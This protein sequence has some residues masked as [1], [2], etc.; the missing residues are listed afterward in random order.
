MKFK[1]FVAGLLNFLWNDVITH[2]PWH[3]FRKFFLR[4][5]N[6]KISATCTVLMHTRILCFWNCVIGERSVI[7][8]YV[9]LDCR[10]S[11][12]VIDEDVDIGPYTRIWT[13]GHNPDSDTHDIYHADVIL[14]HHVW[15]AS[16]VTVL[17]GVTVEEG[18]VL[19]AG[20]LVHKNIPAREVWGG[21]PARFIRKRNNLLQYKLRYKAYFE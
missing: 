2:I 4:V 8:Q 1:I 21:T 12:V 20:S 9:L 10:R 15:L 7:N 13:T 3:G 5:F 16:G 18:A 17:P 6:R 14:K 11:K 19:A